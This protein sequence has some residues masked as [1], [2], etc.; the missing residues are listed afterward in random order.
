MNLRPT[1]RL[2]PSL[3][4][5]L[6]YSALGRVLIVAPLIALLWIAIFWAVLLP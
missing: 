1:Q 5:P 2:D 3:I 4:K 6:C